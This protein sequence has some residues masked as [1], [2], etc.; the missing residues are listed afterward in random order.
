MV[1]LENFVDIKSIRLHNGTG[2]D[3]DLNKNEYQE[4]FLAGKGGRC[5]GLTTLPPSCADYLEIWEPQPPG[6]LWVCSRP[7]LELLYLCISCILWADCSA[8]TAGR[9]Y[10]VYCRPT[11]VS[12]LKADCSEYTAGRL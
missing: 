5:V 3:L 9:L 7:V 1:S 12:I 10:C 4:Y 8:Y 6:N 11:V 2:F